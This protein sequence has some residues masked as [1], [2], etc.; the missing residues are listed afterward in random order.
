MY[1][2]KYIQNNMTQQF[3]SIAVIGQDSMGILENNMLFKKN[4]WASRK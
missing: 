2:P 4:Q 1:K 3:P